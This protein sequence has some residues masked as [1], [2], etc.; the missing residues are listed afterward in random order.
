MPGYEH[1]RQ[2]RIAGRLGPGGPGGG[3]RGADRTPNVSLPPGTY[4]QRRDASGEVIGNVVL[5]YGE[6]ASAGAAHPG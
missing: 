6:D 3:A 5:S 4:G 1:R 2:A